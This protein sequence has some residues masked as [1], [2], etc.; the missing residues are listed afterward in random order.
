MPADEW[1]VEVTFFLRAP[2]RE[3]QMD[4]LSDELDGLDWTIAQLP[5]GYLSIFGDS[6]GKQSLNAASWVVEISQRALHNVNI[7]GVLE[8]IAVSSERWR[9]KEILEPS[10]PELLATRDIGKMLGVSRQRVSQLY[11]EHPQFPAPVV[12]TGAGPLWTRSAVDWFVSGWDR[13]PGRR[14]SPKET[15]EQIVVTEFRPRSAPQSLGAEPNRKAARE[16]VEA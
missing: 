16:R 2:L 5:D 9:E 7:E 14:G 13:R 15:E 4:T 12:H 11:R 6:D 10:L 3:E 8:R 1:T